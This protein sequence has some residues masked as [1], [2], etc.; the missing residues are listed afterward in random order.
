MGTCP[1]VG[2]AGRAGCLWGVT[3]GCC[4]PPASGGHL[5]PVCPSSQFNEP[6]EGLHGL[7]VCPQ[8]V[9]QSSPALAPTLPGKWPFSLG[10][11]PCLPSC[12]LPAEASQWG[13]TC[14]RAADMPSL[15]FPSLLRAAWDGFLLGRWE[16]WGEMRVPSQTALK[17]LPAPLLPRD[18]S[19][20]TGRDA[21][22]LACPQA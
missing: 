16:T 21:G 20:S 2:P 13:L 1:R 18:H 4:V 12:L 8:S 11:C 17:G 14:Q 10:A 15:A 5:A 19:G 6:R 3:L 9:C 7:S 22:D